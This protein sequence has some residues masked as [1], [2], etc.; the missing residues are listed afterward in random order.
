MR[1][2]Q[3]C[4]IGATDYDESVSSLLY[5]GNQL[6]QYVLQDAVNALEQVLA[7]DVRE[8]KHVILRLDGGFGTDENLNWALN[9]G[10]QL[11]AKNNSGRR[12]GAWGK[13]ID[14]WQEVEGGRRWVAVPE[15]QP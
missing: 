14:H 8:R 12:A 6:S 15:Q 11:C 3:L 9:L 13:R 10:S 2:R 4:R 7:V 5:P 1:G